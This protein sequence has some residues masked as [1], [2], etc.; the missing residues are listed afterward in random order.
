MKSFAVT[1]L[2][3]LIGVCGPVVSAQTL[4]RIA[5]VT[6]L[7]ADD[8][9]RN[10][11]MV[12]LHG[13]VTFVD[14]AQTF[15]T[16]N[17]GDHGL[18]VSLAKEM[19]CPALGDEIE[20]D[21]RTIQC[22]IAGL[23][24]SRVLAT[25]LRVLGHHKLPSPQKLTLPELN[26]FKHFEKWVSV[27]GHVLRWKYGM[28]TRTLTVVIAGQTTW[29]TVVLPSTQRPAFADQLTGA[30]LRLTGINAGINTHD[31][32]GAMLVPSLAQI[33][34][35]KPGW[36]SAFDA[37]LVSMKDIK[38]GKVPTESRV[39]VRGIVV[40]FRRNSFQ[41]YL[42]G[43]DGAQLNTLQKGW[44]RPGAPD[45]EL[46]DAGPWPA[47]KQGDEVEMVGS[48]G[49]LPGYPLHYGDVR[50]IGHG[51]PTPPQPVEIETLQ[52]YQNT[53]DWVSVE[54]S[55]VAWMLQA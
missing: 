33:E 55:V 24:H 35:L 31:A 14:A 37:P 17:D 51:V 42:R 36:K 47:L 29:S 39:K 48:T 38:T 16:I 21:G 44:P 40:G 43:A 46:V 52:A 53:D 49:I 28:A 11:R 50:V 27:E 15:V 8:A 13:V 41:V 20:V 10:S 32:N 7:N 4:T 3:T 5:E 9:V 25:S 54:G 19:Q 18:G 2:V 22:I 26:S 6:A 30:H 12:K 23:K 1:L 45:E 34:L